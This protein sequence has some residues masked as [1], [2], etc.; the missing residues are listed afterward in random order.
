MHGGKVSSIV[1]GTAKKNWLMMS[2][3][4]DWSKDSLPHRVDFRRRRD[5]QNNLLWR[6]KL[7]EKRKRPA[8]S[9]VAFPTRERPLWYT[10]RAPSI[11]LVGFFPTRHFR[12]F[13]GPL[14][15]FVI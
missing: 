10:T 6:K 9:N 4:E 3:K 1:G 11:F 7:T 15:Y 12:P 5:V 13:Q 14:W 8:R 2:R